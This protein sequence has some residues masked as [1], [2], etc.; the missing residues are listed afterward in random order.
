MQAVLL[1]EELPAFYVQVLR[2]YAM[3][4]MVTIKKEKHM[5]NLTKKMLQLLLIFFSSALLAVESQFNTHFQRRFGPASPMYNTP[6]YFSSKQTK[7]KKRPFKKYR[8]TVR[9][10]LRKNNSRAKRT[11]K[12]K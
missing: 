4:H 2:F 8:E 3:E 6:L 1:Y 10:K 5:R 9:K 11:K 7:P 12:V